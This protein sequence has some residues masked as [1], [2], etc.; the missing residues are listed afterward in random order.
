MSPTRLKRPS[1][2]FL[3]QKEY[4]DRLAKNLADPARVSAVTNSN[5][6]RDPPLRELREYCSVT[7]YFTGADEAHVTLVSNNEQKVVASTDLTAEGNMTLDW[8]ICQYMVG[9]EKPLALANALDNLKVCD[10][11]T[12]ASGK[13]VSYLG[14]PLLSVDNYIIGGLCVAQYSQREWTEMDLMLLTKLAGSLMQIY[15]DLGAE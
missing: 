9:T 12:V 14:V 6:W 5:F 2:D 15:K 3:A 13:I 11:E 10:I 4:Q 8:S 7:R 1:F